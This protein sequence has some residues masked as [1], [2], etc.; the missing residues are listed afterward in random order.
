MSMKPLLTV[1]L[2]GGMAMGQVCD[3]VRIYTCHCDDRMTR[4]DGV[5]VTDHDLKSPQGDCRFA[6]GNGIYRIGPPATVKWQPI[7]DGVPWWHSEY[8]W[9]CDENLHK[10]QHCRPT[11]YSPNLCQTEEKP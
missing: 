9:V 5:R 4:R 2:L 6:V 7:P 1:L 11:K 3:D 10:S 8:R